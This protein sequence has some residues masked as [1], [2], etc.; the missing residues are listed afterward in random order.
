ML[1][2]IKKA[3]LTMKQ[4]SFHD[5]MTA[6]QNFADASASIASAFAYANDKLSEKKDN[7][8]CSKFHL[9][10]AICQF[11]RAEFYF[12]CFLEN[13]NLKYFDFDDI[14]YTNEDLI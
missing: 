7:L 9:S 3:G 6:A 8:C 11:K 5:I 10:L 4:N 13:E 14:P 12:N 2:R 1:P